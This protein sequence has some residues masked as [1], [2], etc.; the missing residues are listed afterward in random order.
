MDGYVT[1]GTELDTKS[2]DKQ[3]ASLE[4][5][6]KHLEEDR[7]ILASQ[8]TI[9]ESD[10]E[11]LKQYDS[12]IEKTSNQIIGLRQKQND[13]VKQDVFSGMSFHLDGIIKKVAKWGLALFGIR[14]IYSAIRQSMST[15]SQQDEN[16]ASQIEYIRWAV[17]NAIAPVVKFIINGVYLILQYVNQIT[18]ALFGWDLF[19]GPKEF[20]KSMKSASGSA[21]EIKKS[22]AGFDEMNILGDNTTASGGGGVSAP[23]FDTNSV[24]ENINKVK[25]KFK[26]LS[27]SWREET[28]AMGKALENPKAF[29]EA[30]GN[31][32]WLM[33]GIT[34]MGYSINNI[35]FGFADSFGGAFKII[36]GIFTNDSKLI[37]DGFKQLI[38]GF[39][40]LLL[41]YA[42][43][44]YARFEIIT[45][46]I[47][48]LLSGV[49]NWLETSFLKKMRELFG[50]I[51][52]II[53][54]P[55][56]SSVALIKGYFESGVNG[57]RKMFDGLIKF[58][59]GDFKGG[60]KSVFGGLKDILLAPF[61]GMRDGVNKI[62]KGLNKIKLP[63]VLGGGKISIPEI[64]K[65]AKGTILNNPGRGV[66]IGIGGEVGKEAILP[67]SDSRLLEE[68]GSTIGRYITI[69]LTNETKLDGRTIARKVIEI[70]NSENFLRNR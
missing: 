7:E 18:R 17:A 52:S 28:E 54:Y 55:I 9:S 47:K 22:L 66:P 5:K 31:W 60:I 12:E 32:D 30:Y 44:V 10:L 35:I 57:I 65:F 59:K 51:G 21:K 64:P 37:D 38:Q 61:R 67:L 25:S 62:I 26:E 63:G 15:L 27:R 43:F 1:I 6:L 14:S 23:E 33:M 8:K 49:L 2:F 46:T 39:K 69:N 48:G 20:S 50:P 34:R 68:L 16:L 42:S 13:L 4:V 41:G 40:E 24:I 3:I 29:R 58:F 36:K 19:K 45:G 53:T 11:L 70:N 56:I